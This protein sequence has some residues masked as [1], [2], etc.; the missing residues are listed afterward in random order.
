MDKLQECS[1][2]FEQLLN[3]EYNIIIGR[4]NKNQN[5]HLA[6]DKS[7]F[8]HLIGLHK[9]L[10]YPDIKTQSKEKIFNRILNGS[11]SYDFISKSI[12]FEKIQ[13]RFQPFSDIQNI[14]DSNKL[15][16]KYNT[17]INSFSVIQ[18]EYLLST[19][20]CNNDIYIFLDKNKNTGNYFCRSFFPK[21][22]KDYTIGQTSYTLLYKEKINT[23]TGKREVQYDKLYSYRTILTQ[24]AELLNRAGLKF[25][26]KKINDNQSMI[27]FYKCDNKIINSIIGEPE[28]EQ[29]Q[30]PHQ[31]KI[32]R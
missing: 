26:I 12:Y 22:K 27:R 14:L 10:D 11:L 1:K 23:V 18:A 30:P 13:N 28:H 24:D 31:P 19:P 4:K 16:F 5:I 7:D 32:K 21:D 20:C 9:L 29:E 15:V 17:H 6:F 2:A 8:F 25:D 3:I